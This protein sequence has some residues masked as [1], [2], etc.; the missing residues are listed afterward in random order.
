MSD[1]EVLYD[2]TSGDP[3]I[4][5]YDGGGTT[6]W[7]VISVHPDALTDPECRVLD[8]VTYFAAGE[9][10]GNEFMQVDQMIAL[11]EEWP[12]AVLG[13]EHWVLYDSSAGR[14]DENLV[15]L[16]RINAAFRY[17]LHLRGIEREL[18]TSGIS[19][20]EMLK[21]GIP[22]LLDD[23]GMP[24]KRPVPTVYRQNASFGKNDMKDSVLERAFFCGRSLYSL[25]RGSTHARDSTKHAL[26]FLKRIKVQPKLRAEAFPA[27]SAA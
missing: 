10:Y 11:A 20:G 9:F 25:T 7:A 2:G 27:L 17:G 13:V 8:N 5:W 1:V 6:G 21:R 3:T 24:I 15:S 22:T 23:T 4:I 14:K 16:V 12:G 26:T 18:W 19:G